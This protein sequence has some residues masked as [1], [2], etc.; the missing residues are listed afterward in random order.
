[1]DYN[2]ILRRNSIINW[3]IIGESLMSNRRFSLDEKIGGISLLPKP[4]TNGTPWTMESESRFYKSKGHMF[5]TNNRTGTGCPPRRSWRRTGRIFF[6]CGLRAASCCWC[7]G[8]SLGI[9]YQPIIYSRVI[10][11]IFSTRT[12]RL[13]GAELTGAEWEKKREKF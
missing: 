11:I 5:Q 10:F 12:R 9:K 1:M 7:I 6:V 13:L 2:I 8:N 4:W 3:H